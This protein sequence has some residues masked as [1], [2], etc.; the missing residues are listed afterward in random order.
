MAT[1]PPSNT[2]DFSLKGGSTLFLELQ[3]SDGDT[4]VR[5]LLNDKGVLQAETPADEAI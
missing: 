4:P 3:P 2:L 1:L 5:F